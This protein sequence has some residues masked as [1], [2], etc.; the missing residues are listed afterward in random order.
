MAYAMDIRLSAS[1]LASISKIEDSYSK[2]GI[3]VND[4]ESY[5]KEI[6]SFEHSQAEG[7]KILN[8]VRMQA[9]ETGCSVAAAKRVLWVLCR[10]WELE[11]LEL[12][13]EREA[14][15]EGCSDTLRPGRTLGEAMSPR[16]VIF[17]RCAQR[18]HASKDTL[19]SLATLSELRV[20]EPVI[21]KD[22]ERTLTECT[23]VQGKPDLGLLRHPDNRI[24]TPPHLTSGP[25]RS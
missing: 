14:N 10:E 15:P 19:L 18:M 21:V 8:M 9:D 13:A 22:V 4:I 11:H 5:E 25:I 3:I 7:G 12:V 16:S 2:L 17:P 1:E 23:F 20:P 6:R 24:S